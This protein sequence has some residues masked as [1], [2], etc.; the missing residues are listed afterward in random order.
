MPRSGT[1][2]HRGSVVASHL[3]VADNDILD[4]DML[5]EKSESDNPIMSVLKEMV[6]FEIMLNPLFVLIC[7]SNILGKIKICF[8]GSL[9]YF[10]NFQC[11]IQYSSSK[12]IW[13]E[14]LNFNVH[15][16]NQ[17][18]KVKSN[19]SVCQILII[20]SKYFFIGFLAVY[21]PYV[22]LPGMTLEKGIDPGST[23]F[24]ISLIGVSNTVGRVVIGALGPDHL[25]SFRHSKRTY[26]QNSVM[27]IFQP[28]T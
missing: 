22:Y 16:E 18:L 27:K 4:P 6:D 14:F 21:V 15:P 8:N 7:I 17:T 13:C 12:T 2:V 10:W 5:R 1:F 26:V 19:E 24:I 9:M 25:I 28:M 20:I 3:F 11:I 23:A